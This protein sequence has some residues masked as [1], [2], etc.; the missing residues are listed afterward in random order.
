MQTVQRDR[1]TERHQN[2]A[3]MTLLAIEQSLRDKL[4]V[5]EELDSNIIQEIADEGQMRWKSKNQAS[6]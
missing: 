5:V 6:S 3:E 2:Q 4:K 1:G